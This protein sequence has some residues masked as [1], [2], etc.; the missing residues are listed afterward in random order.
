MKRHSLNSRTLDDI[1]GERP[2]TKNMCSVIMG[3]KER[4]NPVLKRSYSRLKDPR[5]LTMKCNV[6]A[7]FA[8]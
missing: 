7:Q 8:A 5:D 3:R 2:Q 6:R 4:E 1:V